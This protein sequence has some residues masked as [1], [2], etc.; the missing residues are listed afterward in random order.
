MTLRTDGGTRYF[1]VNRILP[2]DPGTFLFPRP[3]IFSIYYQALT[4]ERRSL[5]LN[6][7]TF[8]SFL[9]R[10]LSDPQVNSLGLMVLG[11]IYVA[12]MLLVFAIVS[13]YTM[14]YAS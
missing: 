10:A 6:L 11:L 1:V 9:A 5:H 3:L 8:S 4:S 2:T 13:S 14:I 12:S 7:I